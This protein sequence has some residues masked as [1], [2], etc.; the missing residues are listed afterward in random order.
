MDGSIH[1]TTRIS[2]GAVCFAILII[3]GIGLT[4]ASLTGALVLTFGSEAKLPYSLIPFFVLVLCLALITAIFFIASYVASRVSHQKLLFDALMHGLATWS[5]ISIM[6]VTLLFSATAAEG[7]RRT[8]GRF[9]LGGSSLVTEVDI[10][11]ARAV[12]T[13]APNQHPSEHKPTATDQ[14]AD[15]LLIW[16]WWGCFFALIS[17]LGASVAGSYLAH[18]G[19]VLQRS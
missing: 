12:T 1:N 8:L 7:L 19:R 10:L 17:G 9:T 11:K 15:W 13:F 6:L 16:A 5:C 3:I 2:L 4:F 18:K 14:K